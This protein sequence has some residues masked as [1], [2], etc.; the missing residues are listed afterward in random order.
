LLNIKFIEC[1]IPI[2]NN[3]RKIAVLEADCRDEIKNSIN[4]DVLNLNILVIYTYLWY[5]EAAV[6]YKTVE[7]IIG[8]T[9]LV[10]LE[11]INKTS[12]TI[13]VKLE[14]HNPGGS[15]KDRAALNM[16][17]QAEKYG[18]LKP[19][20]RIIEAT[21]GN[22]GIA[23]SMIAAIKG[24]KITLVMPDTASI[25]RR[26]VMRAYGAEIVLTSSRRGMEAAIDR[27]RNME[28]NKEGVILD[29]F[30][31][32]ANPEAHYKGTGPELWEQTSGNLDYFVSA[33]G[34]TG[35]IMGTSRFLKEKNPSVLIVGVQPEKGA[36]IPGIRKWSA[37]YLPVFFQ[38]ERIDEIIEVSQDAAW[39]TARMLAEEEGIFCGISGGGNIAAVLRLADKLENKIITAIIPDK[40][41][42][43]LSTGVF[44][45]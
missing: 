26:K 35:T 45:G 1:I 25:E 41:D 14:G 13:L 37:E 44:P 5:K 6:I 21:S 18:E 20:D 29:Q 33:M 3:F 22:T 11:Y 2:E 12:N 10:E 30:S 32:P 40:G 43:Y 24:Y 8:N 23:L 15:V 38:R 31:N 39:K 42:R 27:V 4:R 16:I 34:T 9:P 7:T 36:K 19:G 17:I 28:K